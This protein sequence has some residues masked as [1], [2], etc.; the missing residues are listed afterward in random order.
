MG[1]EWSMETLHM[2]SSTGVSFPEDPAP[3]PSRDALELKT[4]WPSAGS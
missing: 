3:L 1:Q 2:P 4:A